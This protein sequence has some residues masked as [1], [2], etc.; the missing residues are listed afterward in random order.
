[1]TQKLFNEMIINTRYFCFAVRGSICMIV[2][3]FYACYLFG[4]VFICLNVLL[5]YVDVVYHCIFLGESC[6]SI[7]K[8][9][10]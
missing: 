4:C 5:L 3:F 8:V 2:M 6:L 10:P 7:P 1:M 9:S